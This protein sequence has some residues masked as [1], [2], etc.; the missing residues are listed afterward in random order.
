MNNKTF[1]MPAEKDH[2]QCSSHMMAVQDAMDI[3]SGKWKILIIGSLSFGKKRFMELLRD[4][5]GIGAKMLS[6]ELKDLEENDLVKRTV[7]DTKPVTV[8]YELTDYG[9][10]L[11][12][13]IGAIAYWGSEH[14][15]RIFNK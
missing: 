10:T 13:V 12:E 1:K 7:H 8:E 6:K 11:Q 2:A 5:N 4:V 9:A 14:R 15:K 3:L